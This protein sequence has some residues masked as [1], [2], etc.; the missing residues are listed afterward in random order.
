MSFLQRLTARFKRMFG[1]DPEGT[2]M[3]VGHADEMTAAHT[4]HDPSGMTGNTGGAPLNWVPPED[5]GRPRH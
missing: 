4:Q 5:E 1:D 2:P 3:R